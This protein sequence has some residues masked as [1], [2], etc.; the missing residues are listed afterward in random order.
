MDLAESHLEP[1]ARPRLWRHRIRRWICL[2]AILPYAA[3]VIIFVVFQRNLMYRPTVAD[4]LSISELAANDQFGRDLQLET[5]DGSVLRGWLINAN[6]QHRQNADLAPLVI[7][8]P[9]NSLNRSER[10]SDLHEVAAQGFDVLIFDYRGFGDSTGSP[11]EDALTADALQIWTYAR[12]E[13]GREESQIVL[14]GESIGGAVALSLWA[15]AEGTP[16]DSP[17]PAA[18][19]LNSTFSS[20]PETVVW[21]YPLFPFQFLLLDR[22][23]SIDRIPN[24]NA[25]VVIF[26]GSNDEM[27]P[28]QQGRALARAARQANFIEISDGTHNEIP[29]MQLRA[30]LKSL[31]EKLSQKTHNESGR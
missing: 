21:H 16:P 13:L 23:P 8:F 27:V 14:F 30:E 31:L 11:S 7:Y 6:N 2:Y 26:H 22:W 28:V 12:G 1:S 24:V 3:V 25:P 9:G 10:I 4:S 29:M 17:Q 18:I 19:I 5:A 15:D 20:M